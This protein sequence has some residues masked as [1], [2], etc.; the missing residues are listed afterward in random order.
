[1]EYRRPGGVY[2]SIDEPGKIEAAFE[3]FGLRA[4]D[5]DLVVATDAGGILG[6]GD[7]GVGGI[8]IAIGKL[9]VYTAAPGS[10]PAASS[11]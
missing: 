7:W 5:V 10:I 1:M 2:L 11:R 6:I 3:N 8:E 9:A 4:G